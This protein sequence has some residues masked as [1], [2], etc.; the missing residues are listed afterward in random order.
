VDTGRDPLAAIAHACRHG[1]CRRGSGGGFDRYWRTAEMITALAGWLAP[2][3]GQKF[4]KAAAWAA[5]IILAIPTLLLLKSCYDNSV[6]EN[7]VNEANAEFAEKKDE[8]TGKADTEF[9]QT[10]EGR[11]TARR[12]VEELRDEAIEKGCPVAEYIAS[13]GAEC[14]R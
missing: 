8:S 6:I 1:D 12:T 2:I 10:I 13:N 4:A 7:A 11:E 9:D 14:V 5:I 3:V